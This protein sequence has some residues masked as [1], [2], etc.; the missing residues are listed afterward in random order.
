LDGVFRKSGAPGVVEGGGG[1]GEGGRRGGGE[2][3]KGRGKEGPEKSKAKKLGLNLDIEGINSEFNKKEG[4]KIKSDNANE[5][6]IKTNNLG[7]SLKNDLN[8]KLQSGQDRKESTEGDD[9]KN[10]SESNLN[11]SNNLKEGHAR[12]RNSSFEW[13][14]REFEQNMEELR[15]WIGPEG[16]NLAL[17]DLQ[18]MLNRHENLSKIVELREEALRKREQAQEELLAR[19]QGCKNVSPTFLEASRGQ[20]NLWIQNER[21]QLHVEKKDITRGWLSSIEILRRTKR[22]LKFAVDARTS[23]DITASKKE[24]LMKMLEEEV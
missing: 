11:S 10:Q 2:G 8:E 4:V 23:G 12:K 24:L 14:R 18:G 22:D 9:T 3:G 17:K 16:D 21:K 6:N 20:I 1:G 5:T 19:L 13:L 15:T 7:N